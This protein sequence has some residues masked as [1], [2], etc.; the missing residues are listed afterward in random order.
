MRVKLY[1]IHG[2]QKVSS[3]SPDMFDRNGNPPDICVDD[4][5]IYCCGYGQSQLRFFAS[6]DNVTA[7]SGKHGKKHEDRQ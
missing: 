6:G 7:E 2:G 4:R 1:D 3:Q 5:I